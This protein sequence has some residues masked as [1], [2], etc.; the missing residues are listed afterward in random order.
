MNSWVL[1]F[2]SVVS[3]ASFRR[4]L[5][6]SVLDN[7]IDMVSVFLVC[8]ACGSVRTFVSDNAAMTG[9]PLKGNVMTRL[10]GTVVQ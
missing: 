2:D 1:H 6:A 7:G 4:V 8:Q 3:R 5:A 10:G 9:K